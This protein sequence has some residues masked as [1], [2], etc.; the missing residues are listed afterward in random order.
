MLFRSGMFLKSL[1]RKNPLGG[2]PRNLR[3]MS[4]LRMNEAL[5]TAEFDRA[6]QQFHALMDE[7]SDWEAPQRTHPLYGVMDSATF[8]ALICHHTAHHFH[9][10]GL[11]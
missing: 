10:F 8:S 1:T 5:D 11:L 2:T 4:Q 3:T 9:Q 6:K 7:V